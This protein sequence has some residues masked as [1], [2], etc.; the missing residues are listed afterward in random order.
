MEYNIRTNFIPTDG[1]SEYQDTPHLEQFEPILNQEGNQEFFHPGYLPFLYEY[2]AVDRGLFETREASEWE[3]GEWE[4]H[5][6]VKEETEDQGRSFG[7]EESRSCGRKE[8]TA[9][10]KT[11]ISSLETEFARANYLTRLRRY[12]IAVAL[13]LTERQVKVWFQNRRMKWKRTKGV[14]KHS[15]KKDLESH[16]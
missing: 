5:V 9:F 6:V 2:R 7:E 13:H 12:E 16:T 1:L 15:K 8:R 14:S 10:T 11:Q 4:N 3:W